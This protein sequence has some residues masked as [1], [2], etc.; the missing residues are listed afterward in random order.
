MY[1][2]YF[3]LDTRHVENAYLKK[4]SPA[5]TQYTEQL[6]SITYEIQIYFSSYENTM[7][8]TLLLQVTNTWKPRYLIGLGHLGKAYLENKLVY[9][10]KNLTEYLN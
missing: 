7:S 5:Q 9:E 10:N 4:V 8:N 1:T 6:Y 3:C 2:E